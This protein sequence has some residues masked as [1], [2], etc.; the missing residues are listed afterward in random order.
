MSISGFLQNLQ[1]P[2]KDSHWEEQLGGIW[3]QIFYKIS[4]EDIGDGSIIRGE[5]M[6]PNEARQLSAGKPSRES[7]VLNCQEGWSL[8]W[9][10]WREKGFKYS[11]PRLGE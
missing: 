3:A 1:P 6:R 9:G 8:L 2:N 7:D 4:S 10:W 5:H 11:S